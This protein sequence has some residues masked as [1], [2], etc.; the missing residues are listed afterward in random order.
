MTQD[1]IQVYFEEK[2]KSVKNIFYVFQRKNR[3]QR[4][5]LAKNMILETLVNQSV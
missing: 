1:F 2:N 5:N 3:I 4:V